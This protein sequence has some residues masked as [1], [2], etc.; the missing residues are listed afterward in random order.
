MTRKKGTRNDG[1]GPHCERST[2]HCERTT[3]SRHCEPDDNQ[4]KQSH[5]NTPKNTHKHNYAQFICYNRTFSLLLT[6]QTF[7]QQN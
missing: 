4:A 1:K 7:Y 5:H 2:R 6:S 3:S